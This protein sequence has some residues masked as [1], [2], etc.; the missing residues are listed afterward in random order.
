M[1]KEDLE[2]KIQAIKDEAEQAISLLN[3]TY[4]AFQL[5]ECDCSVFNTFTLF[6]ARTKEEL[7]GVLLAAGAKETGEN[8]PLYGHDKM[9]YRFPYQIGVDNGINNIIGRI[10]Y[11]S[12]KLGRVWI[13]VDISVMEDI[14]TGHSRGISDTEH[15]YFGGVSMAAIR[16]MRISAKTFKKDSVGYHGGNRKLSDESAARAFINSILA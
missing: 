2:Q 13:K 1:K 4:E 9:E 5:T 11:D 10:D 6:R 3:R 12:E 16:E 15:H 14:L 8:N 7:K